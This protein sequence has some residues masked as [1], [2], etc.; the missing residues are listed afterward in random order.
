MIVRL[1]F[2]QHERFNHT[3]CLERRS[4]RLPMH[5]PAV[6]PWHVAPLVITERRLEGQLSVRQAAGASNSTACSLGLFS[7]L[8]AA[9]KTHR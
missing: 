2:A 6:I 7:A 4:C 5:A 8:V 3:Q 9:A 1:P